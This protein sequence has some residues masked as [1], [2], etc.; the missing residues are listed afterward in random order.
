MHVLNIFENVSNI[1]ELKI[2]VLYYPKKKS[3]C[4]FVK[5]K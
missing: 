4:L 3:K 5:S 1:N 2:D